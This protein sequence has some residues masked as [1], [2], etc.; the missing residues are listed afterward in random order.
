[1]VN[2]RKARERAR[3]RKQELARLNAERRRRRLRIGAAAGA[4]LGVLVVA[5]G[6]SYLAIASGG[7]GGRLAAARTAGHQVSPAASPSPSAAT[8]VAPAGAV[9]SCHYTPVSHTPGGRFVGLPPTHPATGQPVA[10]LVTNRG[11]ITL[12]LNAAKAPCTVN[13]FEFLAAHNYFNNTPCHRLT[14]YP[15]APAQHSLGLHV[16]QCGD[17]TGTGTGGPGYKF[18]NENLAGATYPVGTVAMANAGPGTNGS[19]FFLV[20]GPTTLPAQYTPFGKITSG[21][22]VLRAIAAKGEVPT[23]GQPDGKPKESVII[24]S[25]R[26]SG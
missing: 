3:L 8:S 22:G 17:P 5:G 11:T 18:A 1:M 4:A 13:S 20:Y 9:T 24:Q 25:F 10:T 19:Q 26:V 12:A 14:A 6:G 23:N 7:S 21:L 2:A 15:A 16:L